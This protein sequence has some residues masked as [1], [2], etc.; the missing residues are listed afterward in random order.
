MRTVRNWLWLMAICVA[1]PLGGCTTEG[2]IDFDEDEPIRLASGYSPPVVHAW[3]SGPTGTAVPPV[4]PYEAVGA[5]VPATPPSPAEVDLFRRLKEEAAAGD[6]GAMRQIG[7]L[8]AIG[9]GVPQDDRSAVAWLRLAA[10][11]GDRV[12]MYN[13]GVLHAAGR[14]GH[15]DGAVTATAWMRLAARYGDSDATRWLAESGLDLP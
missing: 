2:E 6:G 15:G 4:S 8:Y 7:L 5:P 10:E 14:G 1:A 11:A 13:L 12:A 3:P 9:R